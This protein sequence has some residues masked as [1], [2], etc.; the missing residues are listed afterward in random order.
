MAL[1]QSQLAWL[2]LDVTDGLGPKRIWAIM[3]SL[4]DP[5]AIFRMSLTELEKI[6]LP[7][8]SAQSV[9]SGASRAKAEQELMLIHEAGGHPLTP[10]DELYP[11]RLLE[12]YDPP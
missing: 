3:R 2:T 7:G 10:L 9:A 11:Q 6:G 12:I 8:N 4:K 5:T 1:S